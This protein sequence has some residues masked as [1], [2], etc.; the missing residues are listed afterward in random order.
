M[1]TKPFKMNNEIDVGKLND[2]VNRLS[3]RI[4]ELEEQAKI[5]APKRHWVVTYPDGKTKDIYAHSNGVIACAIIFDTKTKD[6]WK[7]VATVMSGDGV[8]I[9][10]VF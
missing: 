4:D 8:V 1:I 5:N 2:Y 9:E 6:G 10:E 3:S 7:I